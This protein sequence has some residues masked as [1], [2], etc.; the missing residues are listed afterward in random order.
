MNSNDMEVLLASELL[1][2]PR[3]ITSV[4]VDSEW[5]EMSYISLV[6]QALNKLKGIPYTVEQVYREMKAL[7]IFGAG[8]IEELQSLASDA[9][10]LGIERELIRQIRL[11]YLDSRIAK[12]S[13]EYSSTL[14]KTHEDELQRLIIEKRELNHVKDDGRL[15]DSFQEF[16]ESLNKTSEELA[17]ELL[18][19]FKPLDGFL[20]GG[21]TGG[22]L[23]IVAGR[24]GTGKTAL[25]L[26]LMMKLFENNSG[27]RC[28]YFTFEM[29]KNELMVRLVSRDTHINS[30]LFVGK[31][32]LTP[33]NKIKARQS[34]E[35][36]KNENDLRVFTSE[37]SNLEDIKYAIK[38]RAKKGK[39][40]AFVDYAG[41]ITVNDSRKD[42]RR[43]MNEV[44]RELKK[45][46]T[47]YGI[48][49][50]LLAQLSRGVDQRKDKRPTLSDLK[51]SGSLEQDAN[52]VLLLSEEQEG[53]NKVRCEIA[54]NR[55]GA[56]GNVPF[57]FLKQ[58]MEFSIDFDEWRG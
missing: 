57:K 56:V 55:E 20:G 46:T 4:D 54:K 49:I 27:V 18:Q 58:Y 13:R 45:L 34:Y 50:F 51:E 38:N 19:T 47:D 9:K 3:I 11:H 30:L 29:G 36:I 48:T 1:A 7:E 31:D 26:N 35:K 24:P 8:K 14:S 23:A 22:K 39:Y 32:K 41:L 42:E 33:D 52:L 53:S 28:D 5:F 16:S 40:V 12:I 43:V 10:G 6:I 2:N 21:L 44:T 25:A 17:D 15:D 37:Y